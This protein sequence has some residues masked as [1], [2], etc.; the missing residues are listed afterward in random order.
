MAVLFLIYYWEVLERVNSD[1]GLAVC[2][3]LQDPVTTARIKNDSF[4][5]HQIPV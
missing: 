1:K 4:L 3:V 2:S 5:T